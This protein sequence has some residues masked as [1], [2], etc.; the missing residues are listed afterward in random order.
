MT[1][2]HFFGGLLA[3]SWFNLGNSVEMRVQ[4]YDGFVCRVASAR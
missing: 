1:D 3:S 4:A 2:I